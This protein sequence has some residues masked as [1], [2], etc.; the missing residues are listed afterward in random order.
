MIATGAVPTRPPLP[1]IDAAGIFGVQ[2]LDDG[3]A[4]RAALER[5]PP[6]SAV[7]VGAG[8]IGLELA[9]ALC[10]RGI[11]VTVIQRGRTAPVSSLVQS[12]P[13]LWAQ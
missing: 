4:V 8:Y 1:G 3:L 2:T 12:G 6:S 9:E 7:V 11:P 13:A 10:A 5:E